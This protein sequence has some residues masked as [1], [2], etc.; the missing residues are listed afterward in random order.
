MLGPYVPVVRSKSKFLEYVISVGTRRH[1]SFPVNKSPCLNATDDFA[2][3][4]GIRIFAALRCAIGSS[5]TIDGLSVKGVAICFLVRWCR[6]VRE[7]WTI[8]AR[9]FYGGIIVYVTATER[10]VI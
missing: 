9:A 8:G 7:S 3:Q 6:T 1:V 4:S 5:L 10:G 2:N